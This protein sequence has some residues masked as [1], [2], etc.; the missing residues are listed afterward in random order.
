MLE[1]TGGT[2]GERVAAMYDDMFLAAFT[3]DTTMAV[4]FLREFAGDGPALEL[5]V[6]TGR[7][8]LPL[9]EYGVEVLGIDSSEPMLQ[10]LGSK[11]GG[12]DLPVTLG[13]MARFDFDRQFPLIYVVFNTFFSLL[14]QDEQVVCFESVAAHLAPGGV[15]VM[16]AFVPDLGGPDL[17]HQRVSVESIG[18]DQLTVDATTHDPVEQRTE[19]LHVVVQNGKVELYPVKIR[20]AYV[21][22]L[23]LMARI[24]GLTLRERW[25]DWDR[26][27]FPS[28]KMSHVSVWERA[29]QD[30]P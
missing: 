22:E 5:G 6:G 13:D 7:V 27:P 29:D 10:I 11:P 21:S 30:G 4:S 28:A 15:F 2:Y 14:T 18:T 19:N 9:A 26:T 25:S 3:I 17:A 20:Y 1:G 24:A 16:Q 8:A 12:P 23:D